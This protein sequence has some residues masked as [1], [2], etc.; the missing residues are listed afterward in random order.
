MSFS[1][2]QVQN[3]E[4]IFVSWQ[5]TQIFRGPQKFYFNL[6]CA[7]QSVAWIFQHTQLL[8]IPCVPR[9]N[10]QFNYLSSKQAWNNYLIGGMSRGEEKGDIEV[11]EEGNRGAH[12]RLVTIANRWTKSRARSLETTGRQTLDTSQYFGHTLELCKSGNEML[13][14]GKGRTPYPFGPVGTLVG[15]A[16]CRHP[17]L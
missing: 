17:L 7:F 14:G 4:Y 12:R 13:C 16:S 1:S 9:F 2:P 8:A 11:Q 3:S 6:E 10:R 5:S 15:L